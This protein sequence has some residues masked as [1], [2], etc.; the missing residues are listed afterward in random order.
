MLCAPST[1]L[2]SPPSLF[3]YFHFLLQWH[4]ALT[5]TYFFIHYI[6]E[7]FSSN[8]LPTP[9]LCTKMLPGVQQSHIE[10]SYQRHI[11][12]QL[13]LFGHT[14]VITVNTHNCPEKEF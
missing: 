11:S 12:D 4:S 5:L 7:Q 2:G 9:T 14:L 10:F 8:T 13:Q 6:A 1:P 3:A